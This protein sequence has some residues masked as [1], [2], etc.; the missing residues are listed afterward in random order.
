M[1]GSPPK[2]RDLPRLLSQVYSISREFLALGQVSVLSD[3]EALDYFL[4]P[5]VFRITAQM[6]S[7]LD[8]RLFLKSW[9]DS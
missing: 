8:Q 1:A 3:L 4:C 6:V 2:A 5:R 7:L 9:R